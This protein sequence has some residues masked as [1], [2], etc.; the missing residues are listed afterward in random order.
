M[1]KIFGDCLLRLPVSRHEFY[2]WLNGQRSFD[3]TKV[4]GYPS[5]PTHFFNNAFIYVHQLENLCWVIANSNV[6]KRFLCI[7]RKIFSL[8]ACYHGRFISY[9][10]SWLTV[11]LNICV[12]CVSPTFTYTSLLIKT[13]RAAME[14]R[15]IRFDN[16]LWK[17]RPDR[18]RLALIAGSQYFSSRPL[19]S[20]V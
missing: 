17:S 7:I 20:S 4:L 19:P 14:D 15:R 18:L 11:H 8:P 16:H 10:S 3:L 1:R 2:F 6:I 13:F 9:I 5:S 12:G